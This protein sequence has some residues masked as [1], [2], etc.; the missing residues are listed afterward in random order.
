MKNI[1][2]SWKTTLLGIILIGCGL[3]YVFINATPDYIIMSLLIASGI[4]LVFSPDSVI[5]MLN[6]KSK[7]L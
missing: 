5:E 4:G 7:E 1:Y 3:A 6:K 2:K